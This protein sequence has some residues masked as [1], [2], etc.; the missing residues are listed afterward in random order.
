M[1]VVCTNP[2]PKVRFPTITARLDTLLQVRQA[3]KT[4]Y[5]GAFF[6]IRFL[7]FLA[8]QLIGYKKAFWYKR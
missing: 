2:L 6:H 7:G 3:N 8:Q 5:Y 4:Q 1:R